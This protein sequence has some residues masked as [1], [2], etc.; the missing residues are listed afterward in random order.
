LAKAQKEFA[1]IAS[2]F[3]GILASTS[4]KKLPE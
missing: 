1:N 4:F 3:L 2:R